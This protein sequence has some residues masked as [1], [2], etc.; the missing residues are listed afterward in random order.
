LTSFSIF[1]TKSPLDLLRGKFSA[2]FREAIRYRLAIAFG[3]VVLFVV[4]DRSVVFFQMWEGISAWYP[5]AGLALALLVGLDL[6]YAPLLLVAGMLA[7]VVNY[8]L[9]IFSLGFWAV[10]SAVAVGYTGAAYALRRLRVNISFHS[11][12]D[13]NLFVAV[14]LAASFCVAATGTAAFIWAGTLRR[15]DYPKAV[16]NWWVGDA[17]ALICLT[18]FLLIHFTPWLRRR[19]FPRDLA[20]SPPGSV[21]RF[22]L[23]PVLPSPG[24]LKAAHKAPASF[25]RCG[26]CSV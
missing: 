13:V 19:A 24:G 26:L 21:P 1:G 12:R 22:E 5:P 23:W 10:N 16:L 17:V 2:S 9:S 8:P 18:P 4:L 25:S 15:A 11:L 20:L 14:A 6:A 7:A 3:F